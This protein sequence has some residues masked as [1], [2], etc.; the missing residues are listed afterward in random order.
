M[1]EDGYL[2][3][4]LT[5][6]S[7]V[8]RIVRNE[9]E[10]LLIKRSRKPFSG[11]FALP[12]AYN[13]SGETT[14]QALMRTLE[15]KAG[16]KASD[17]ALVE[18]LYTFDTVA[19]DPRGH[20]VSV[21]YTCLGREKTLEPRETS[22]NPQFFAVDNLPS[23]AYDHQ[24]IIDYAL[25]RLRHKITYTNAMYALLPHDFTFLELQTA[26]EAILGKTLDK[27]NFRKKFMSLEL[28][29]E[30][31]EMRRDGPHRPAKLYSFK[32]NKLVT[33]HANFD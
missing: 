5:V 32:Q 31:G 15:Q 19:R 33:L 25:T 28:I 3:P 4:I 21:T 20:A 9:L 16:L 2:P 26:Y 1:Y 24:D 10:V 22:E 13:F 12:G 23:L 29:K 18:Q 7:V 6:D 11:S 8:F 27:R 14:R 30:T 17:I